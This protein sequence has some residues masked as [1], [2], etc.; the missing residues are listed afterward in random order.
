MSFMHWALCTGGSELTAE[1]GSLLDDGS[2]QR[3]RGL[4]PPL[5]QAAAPEAL[6]FFYKRGG[7]TFLVSRCTSDPAYQAQA[8]L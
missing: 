7:G 1:L 3:T 5:R 6:R 8:S 4:S 2:V